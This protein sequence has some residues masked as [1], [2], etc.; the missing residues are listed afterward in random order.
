MAVGTGTREPARV[1]GG[2][3]D[4]GHLEELR[5]DPHRPHGSGSGPSAATSACSA[6]PT[7]TW[8]C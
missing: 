4:T 1:S 5:V 2:E 3:G 6:W 7:A 8:C